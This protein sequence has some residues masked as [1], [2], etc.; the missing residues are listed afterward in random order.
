MFGL[1]HPDRGLSQREWL[2][3][4]V[5]PI[6]KKF[7]LQ[8][9]TFLQSFLVFQAFKTLYNA[10]CFPFFKLPLWVSCLKQDTIS[11]QILFQFLCRE[12]LKTKLTPLTFAH[13]VTQYHFLQLFSF[14]E[15][16]QGFSFIFV[17]SSWISVSWTNVHHN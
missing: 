15:T 11:L 14:Q 7:R 9:S 13:F 2:K 17:C 8:T 6:S 10:F 1:D 12:F 5:I 4:S 3:H 16:A